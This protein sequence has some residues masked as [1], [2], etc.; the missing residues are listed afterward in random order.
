MAIY[1]AANVLMTSEAHK[2]FRIGLDVLNTNNFRTMKTEVIQL[3]LIIIDI[4]I[5]EVFTL[6]YLCFQ[7]STEDV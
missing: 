5:H 7:R 4:F 1:T 6:M 3:I 2:I